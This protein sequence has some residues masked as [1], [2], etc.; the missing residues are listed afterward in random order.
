VTDV[1][2]IPRRVQQMEHL[3]CFAKSVT[4][5]IEIRKEQ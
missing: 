3:W 2:D 1:N 5:N 4:G